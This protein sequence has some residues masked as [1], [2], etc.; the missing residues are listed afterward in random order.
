MSR[1]GPPTLALLLRLGTSLPTVE[2]QLQAVIN[3]WMKVPM[4]SLPSILILFLLFTFESHFV[5]DIVWSQ[6]SRRCLP[7]PSLYHVVLS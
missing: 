5:I 3:V 1:L 6:D 4:V 2:S 7:L